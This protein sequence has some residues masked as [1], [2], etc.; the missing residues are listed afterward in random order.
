MKMKIERL[1]WF[2]CLAVLIGAQIG[3]GTDAVEEE[4]LLEGLS[5][6]SIGSRGHGGTHR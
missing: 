3:W 6:R 4:A 5:L 2:L 1:G